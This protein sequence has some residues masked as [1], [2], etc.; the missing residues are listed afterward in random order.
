MNWLVKRGVSYYCKLLRS[1]SRYINNN[2]THVRSNM[3]WNSECALVSKS[4]KVVSNFFFLSL[5]MSPLA[6]SLGLS[7]FSPNFAPI[8]PLWMVELSSRQHL[9]P[10]SPFFPRGQDAW[11]VMVVVVCCWALL[12]TLPLPSCT[13]QGYVKSLLRITFPMALH[14]L[15][16]GLPTRPPDPKSMRRASVVRRRKSE[17]KVVMNILRRRAQVS[18]DLNVL[19]L[20]CM[21]C[22][23][24]FLSWK[25]D[26][27]HLS[28]F[29]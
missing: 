17:E 13:H 19:I 5:K 23:S 9:T 8:S 3:A 25:W 27:E 28:T 26:C 1:N 4:L 29:E 16:T 2:K 12:N 21:M 22:D 20:N 7:H 6:A 11:G 14:S 10:L 15:S 24:D 18:K